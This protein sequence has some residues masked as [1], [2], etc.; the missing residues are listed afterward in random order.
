VDND[1]RTSQP[2]IRQGNV[3]WLQDCEPLDD[4]NEKDRPVVVV[5]DPA[6]LAAGGPVIVVACSTKD[7]NEPD[8][9]K[10]PDKSTE[11]QTKSGLKKPSYAI[12]RWH[13]PVERERLDEYK[14]YLTG[15][16]LRAVLAAYVSRSTSS[17]SSQT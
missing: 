12:P 11:P 10:L 17:D 15:K 13:F 2:S 6:S 5:D 3:Y 1:R 7:R 9:V 16:V 8:Q 14:G 4:D